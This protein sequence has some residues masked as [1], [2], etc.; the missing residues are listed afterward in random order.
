MPQQISQAG[1]T[2]LELL[3]VIAIIAILAAI[4][5][6]PLNKA[7]KAAKCVSELAKLKNAV[8]TAI[9]ALDDFRDGSKTLAQAL[10]KVTPVCD[11]LNAL[12]NNNCYK[13]NANIALD[14]LLNEMKAKVQVLRES[15]DSADQATLDAAIVNC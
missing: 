13:K 5:L 15:L 2:L 4:I 10:A 3:V 11:K 6:P 14:A 7:R 8:A 12:H 1:F 9:K